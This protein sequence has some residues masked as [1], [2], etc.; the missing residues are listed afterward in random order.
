MHDLNGMKGNITMNP[1]TKAVT[2][3]HAWKALVAHHQS[4]RDLHLRKLFGDDLMH[5]ERKTLEQ[6][7]EGS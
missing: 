6:L 7:K 4:V 3:R 2:E 1:A 5:G